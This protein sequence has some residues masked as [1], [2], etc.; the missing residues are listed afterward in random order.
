MRLDYRPETKLLRSKEKG[1][2]L[3]LHN[4]RL[5]EMEYDITLIANVLFSVVK[6]LWN[7]FRRCMYC[8]ASN[9]CAIILLALGSGYGIVD[10]K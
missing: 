5:V 2:I 6:L 3:D 8:N 7:I 1:G 4:Y 9:I 10:C